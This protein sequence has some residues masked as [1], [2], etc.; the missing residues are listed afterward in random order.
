MFFLKHRTDTREEVESFLNIAKAILNNKNFCLRKN[1]RFQYE[2]LSY[3][4]NNQYTNKSTLLDLDYGLDDVVNEIKSLTIEQYKE[5]IIDNM[6]G[7]FLPFYCFI[8]VINRRQVYIKIKISE[9]KENQVFCV[10]FH[11]AEFEVCESEFP[12]KIKEEKL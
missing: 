12:Y 3:I 6:P 9:E 2:R 10:S 8:K 1:F 4:Q 11:F 5:T 7:K